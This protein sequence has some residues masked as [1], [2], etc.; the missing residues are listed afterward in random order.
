M[1][2]LFY[3]REA[4]PTVKVGVQPPFPWD[5]DEDFPSVYGNLPQRQIFYQ[6]RLRGHL[7]GA[8]AN[9]LR[10]M[11]VRTEALGFLAMPNHVSI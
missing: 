9:E 10:A 7:N 4:L 1:T 11:S 3:W 8:R 2:C 6:N 5:E